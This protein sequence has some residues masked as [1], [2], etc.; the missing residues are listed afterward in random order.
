MNV[1]VQMV[2]A[3]YGW[4][5]ISDGE[6]WDEELRLARLAADLGFDVLWS[7][8]HHFNVYSF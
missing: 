2:F 8:E 5:S 7:V 3:S 4:S 6:V 1:G